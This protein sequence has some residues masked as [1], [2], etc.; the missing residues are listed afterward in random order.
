MEFKYLDQ[1]DFEKKRGDAVN[2]V[3]REISKHPP[4]GSL[5]R[6][7]KIAY[8]E[9]FKACLRFLEEE[10][11]NPDISSTVFDGIAE[12]VDNVDGEMKHD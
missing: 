4:S 2:G 7:T 1:S 3:M 10:Y 8:N 9:G 11:W 5:Q 12:E 6:A